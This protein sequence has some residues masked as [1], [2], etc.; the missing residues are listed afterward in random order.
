MRQRLASCLL[1]LVMGACGSNSPTGPGTTVTYSFTINDPTQCNCGD[2]I[3]QYTLLVNG[4]G[5]LEAV[6]TWQET[7]ATVV[8]RLLSPD[9]NTVHATSTASS[10]TARLNHEVSRGTYRMQVILAPGGG[11]KATFQVRITHP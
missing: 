6:A 11:R 10:T 9:F 2:G 4:S 1:A 5:P 3:A 7:D 8:V